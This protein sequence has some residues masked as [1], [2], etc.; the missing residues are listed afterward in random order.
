[1]AA[2]E[3]GVFAVKN[4]MIRLEVELLAPKNFSPRNQFGE[5]QRS[6]KMNGLRTPRE[7]ADK[8]TIGFPDTLYAVGSEYQPSQ[9]TE[10]AARRHSDDSAKGAG[11]YRGP[12]KS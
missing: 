3:V 10:S 1:M 5:G 6:N 4:R 9:T 2:L 7:M 8:L 12:S 11:R